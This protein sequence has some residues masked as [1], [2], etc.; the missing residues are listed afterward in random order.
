MTILIHDSTLRDGNHAA[1]HNLSLGAVE[2]H[3]YLADRAGIYSV[4]VGHGNGLGASSFQVGICPY[5]DSEII[6]TARNALK[7]TKLAVHVMPGFA[8]FERD[9]KPALDLGVDIF[10]VGTHCTEANL[11]LSFLQN[12]NKYNV[13]VFSCLMMSHMTSSAEL[14]SQAKFMEANGSHGICIYDSAGSY[15]LERTKEVIQLLVENLSIPIGFHGHNNLGLAVANSYVAI[16]TGA[17]IIDASICSYGAGAGNTQF[18]VLASLLSSKAIDTKINLSFLYDLVTYASST[19]AK[20]KPFSY[21]LSIVS[22]MSGVFSGFA[23]HVLNASAINN[24]NSLDLFK[25]LGKIGIVGG[26]EDQIYAI[27]TKIADQKSKSRKHNKNPIYL[28]LNFVRKRSSPRKVSKLEFIKRS[29]NSLIG[30][31]NVNQDIETDVLLETLIKDVQSQGKLYFDGPRTLGYGGYELKEDYWDEI[32]EELVKEFKIDK[33]DKI[34]D[35]GCA[36][37]YLIKNFIKNGFPKSY[38]LDISEYA[39]NSAPNEIVER[40]IKASV[41]KI[42]FPDDFFDF[43]ICLDVLQELSED[44]IPTALREIQRVS[45]TSFVVVPAAKNEDLISK[46]NF[47]NWSISA[48]VA[49]TKQEWEEIFKNSD[50]EKSFSSFCLDLNV[51]D[52]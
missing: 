3:C 31:A 39:I 38:G 40:L 50:Y 1:K 24:I 8:T 14:L 42:P 5:K 16:K 15:D 52:V 6:S 20:R 17:K 48:K 27:A 13:Q 22:G 10:R 12:L 11:S 9:I 44:T 37:G 45:K 32:R 30:R 18:E 35:I 41:L 26:Q 25:E 4:E 21:P 2:N 7:N 36:K 34:L 29:Q 33:T 23:N 28:E 46:T 51:I 49:K 19:Y 47:L 43:T